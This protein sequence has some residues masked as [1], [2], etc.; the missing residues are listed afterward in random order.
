ML[1][2]KKERKQSDN[3]KGEKIKEEGDKC[4]SRKKNEDREKKGMQVMGREELERLNGWRSVNVRDRFG[5]KREKK[6]G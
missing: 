5:G 3:R 1:K 2:K 6:R 4:A